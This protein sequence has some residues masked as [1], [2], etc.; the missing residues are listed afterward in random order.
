MPNTTA[1]TR[2]WFRWTDDGKPDQALTPYA[3]T[4]KPR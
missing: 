4:R 2:V 1:C 3:D